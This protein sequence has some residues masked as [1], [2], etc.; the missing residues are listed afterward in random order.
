MG[1]IGW[2]KW[3]PLKVEELLVQ[4]PGPLCLKRG[5]KGHHGLGS[6]KVYKVNSCG[7]V[8]TLLGDKLPPH[9]HTYGPEIYKR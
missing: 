4:Y 8:G 2:Y 5:Y 7:T 6:L 3:E 9:P 1:S